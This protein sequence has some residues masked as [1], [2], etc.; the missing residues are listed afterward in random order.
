M[1]DPRVILYD[2]GHCNLHRLGDTYKS[3]AALHVSRGFEIEVQREPI[4]REHLSGVDLFVTVNPQHPDSKIPH[5]DSK[6]DWK[7]PYPGSYTEEEEEA[8]EE[9][10]DRGGGLLLVTNHEPLGHF[11]NSLSSRF[12]MRPGLNC[13]SDPE[14][15][16][17][18]ASEF[19][20]T[21]HQKLGMLGEHPILNGK[22]RE[23][24]IYRVQSFC[25]ETIDGNGDPLLSLGTQARTHGWYKKE[26]IK[27]APR[28]AMARATTHGEG[29][30]AMVGDAGIF[31]D[32]RVKRIRLQRIRMGIGAADNKQFA[33][34]IVRWLLKEL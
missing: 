20:V 6:N 7:A 17:H 14:E 8:I 34:N 28:Q 3:F 26:E 27:P 16:H 32:S 9:F 11:V 30:V 4:T 21:F 18:K 25:G 10:V 24:K 5:P 15:D 33:A 12:G 19:F 29:R 22:C 31:R 1:P 23:E 13:T 2:E